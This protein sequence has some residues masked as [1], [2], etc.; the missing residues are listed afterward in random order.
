MIIRLFEE[1]MSKLLKQKSGTEEIFK[2]FPV[3]HKSNEYANV[4]LPKSF[5]HFNN[6]ARCI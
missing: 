6:I 5:S 3:N 1:R 2:L 4:R